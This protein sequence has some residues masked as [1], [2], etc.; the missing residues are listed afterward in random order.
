LPDEGNCFKKTAGE[1]HRHQFCPEKWV[2]EKKRLPL[3]EKPKT[4]PA[5]E[6]FVLDGGIRRGTP[7]PALTRHLPLKGKASKVALYTV[8]SS[9]GR[10]QGMRCTPCIPQG[11]GFKDRAVRRL[12]LKGKA[13]KAVLYAACS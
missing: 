8:Y 1:F 12:F 6:V 13:S 11:E 5:D 4:N 7:H 2:R 3:E 9:G 10:L